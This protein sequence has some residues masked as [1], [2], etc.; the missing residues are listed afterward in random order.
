MTALSAS[1]LPGL[2]RSGSTTADGR[3]PCRLGPADESA[4]GWRSPVSRVTRWPVRLPSS[5]MV[6]ETPSQLE[7]VA[8]NPIR[9][10]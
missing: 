7:W 1:L 2:T 8:E 10:S 5:S 3:A 4:I 9:V 6:G